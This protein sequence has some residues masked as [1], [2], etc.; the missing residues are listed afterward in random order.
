MLR[1][2]VRSRQIA[3]FVEYASGK[4]LPAYVYGCPE[5]YLQCKEADGK[6]AVGIWNFIA[7]EALD[8]EVQLA[9][10]YSSVKFLGCEGTLK[11]DK[12]IIK[13]IPAFGFGFFELEK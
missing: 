11:G 1:N 7:D 3:E 6:L 2:Y 4:K 8:F 13:S 12:V 10:E 9:E 5:M